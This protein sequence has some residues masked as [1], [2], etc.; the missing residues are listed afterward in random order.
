MGQ[1]VTGDIHQM[2]RPQETHDTTCTWSPV[3]WVVE[4]KKVDASAR[5]F[6][7]V[8]GNTY[9]RQQMTRAGAKEQVIPDSLPGFSPL[10]EEAC[11][12]VPGGVEAAILIAVDDIHHLACLGRV[13]AEPLPDL[14]PGVIQI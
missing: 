7:N 10:G 5:K 14:D 9:P 6:E 11:A 12:L 2:P 4:I 13:P 3:G 8:Q 1:V